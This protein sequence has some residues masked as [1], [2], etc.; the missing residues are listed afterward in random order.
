VRWIEHCWHAV[1]SSHASNSTSDAAVHILLHHVLAHGTS[2]HARTHS[3]ARAYRTVLQAIPLTVLSVL[4]EDTDLSSTSRGLFA[5]VEPEFVKITLYVSIVIGVIAISLGNYSLAY[6]NPLYAS[7]YRLV[8]PI[9]SSLLAWQLGIDEL[10]TIMFWVGSF[11][12]LSGLFGVAYGA[13]RRTKQTQQTVEP[14]HSDDFNDESNAEDMFEMKP[15]T[16]E[17]EER[18]ENG[19]STDRTASADALSRIANQLLTPNDEFQ[20]LARDRIRKSSE[21]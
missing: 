17:N 19:N 3:S 4:I 2:T 18:N 8:D 16:V 5:W 13:S 20:E 1:F 7:L 15:F 6:I 11:I 14:V 10:P 9:L 12:T 21:N